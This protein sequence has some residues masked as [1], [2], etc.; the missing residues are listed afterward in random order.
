MSI[1]LT[2]I[3][4]ETRNWFLAETRRGAFTVDDCGTL[5][6]G[7]LSPG[8]FC[9]LT[10]DGGLPRL[11]PVDCLGRLEGAEETAFTGTVQLLAPPADF[12]R[13]CAEIAEWDAAHPAD[14]LKRETLGDY[15]YE[16]AADAAGRPL[17]WRN[18]FAARLAPWR[19]LIPEVKDP[20]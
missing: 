19:R 11:Y 8:T 5:A 6:P 18:V 13:L 16:R 17:D 14:G 3:M 9:L 20:C 7:T 15:S 4:R 1:T 10:P 2:D 12:L